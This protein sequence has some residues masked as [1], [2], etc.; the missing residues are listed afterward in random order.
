MKGGANRAASYSPADTCAAQV[1]GVIDALNSRRSKFGS[2][3][4]RPAMR[5]CSRLLLA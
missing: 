4:A 3:A 1:L 5:G 2:A